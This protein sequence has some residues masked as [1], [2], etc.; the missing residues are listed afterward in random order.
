M[1]DF[2]IAHL[3][4]T[5][6]SGNLKFGRASVFEMNFEKSLPKA[7]TSAPVENSPVGSVSPARTVSR[8][9]SFG[10]HYLANFVTPYASW[11]Y[12]IPFCAKA[13]DGGLVLK[14][15]SRSK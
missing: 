1:A 8:I 13:S 15:A 5:E 3:F 14:F 11:E 10:V 9:F 4:S 12:R 2:D 7:T 6:I